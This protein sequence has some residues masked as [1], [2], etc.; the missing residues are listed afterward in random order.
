MCIYSIVSRYIQD[1]NKC[2]CHN[3]DERKVEMRFHPGP[4]FLN[5]V[6]ADIQTEFDQ[7]RWP[8]LSPI[9]FRMFHKRRNNT[10]L[11]RESFHE[12]IDDE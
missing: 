10:I 1:G 7:S 3:R 8:L 11:M 9:Q 12:Y 5:I 2:T 6:Y 4:L